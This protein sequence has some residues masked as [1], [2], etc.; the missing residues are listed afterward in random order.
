MRFPPTSA[1]TAGAPSTAIANGSSGQLDG[2]TIPL[3]LAANAEG[4][5]INVIRA[6]TADDLQE[7]LEDARDSDR[8]TLIAVDTSADDGVPTYESWWDV[9]VS[10]VST[11]EGVKASRE[12]YAEAVKNERP[13]I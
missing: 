13:L 5:G 2:D 1:P 10:E 8:S 11:L 3:D 7:A 4:L 12:R 6:D 9:P